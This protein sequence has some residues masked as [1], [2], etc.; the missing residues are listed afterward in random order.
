ME[1]KQQMSLFTGNL[2]KQVEN[3]A[4][5]ASASMQKLDKHVDFE[6]KSI[7]EESYNEISK[8]LYRV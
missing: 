7:A 2:M 1:T 6:G 8:M 3:Y 5:F 4:E